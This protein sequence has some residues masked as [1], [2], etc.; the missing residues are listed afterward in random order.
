MDSLLVAA[1]GRLHAFGGMP[2]IGRTTPG[3]DSGAS[4]RPHPPRKQLKKLLHM[5][6]QA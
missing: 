6:K 1:S 5:I 3:S 4:V 2:Q